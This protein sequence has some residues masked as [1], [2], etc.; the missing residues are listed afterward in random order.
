MDPIDYFEG[1]T[2]KYAV[3]N[4]SRSSFSLP[5]ALNVC[6][7]KD[8]KNFPLLSTYDERS[9]LEMHLSMSNLIRRM[10]A[11]LRSVQARRQRI[12]SVPHE[13]TP[14]VLSN[15]FEYF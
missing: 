3:S 8:F 6:R 9:T 10:Q 15:Y 7:K 5:S 1:M 2:D 14:S 12:Y 4:S 11:A 13:K